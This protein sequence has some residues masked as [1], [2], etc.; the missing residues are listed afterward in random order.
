M[1]R[2]NK[3]DF[4]GNARPETDTQEK[5]VKGKIKIGARQNVSHFQRSISNRA[6]CQV[7]DK[8]KHKFLLIKIKVKSDRELRAVSSST[9][10]KGCK[11]S[12]EQLFSSSID[13]YGQPEGR[14]V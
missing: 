12:N 7:N 4:L 2:G 13:R 9:T 1:R 6:K 10:R 8:Q 3:F 11:S 5:S 14:D